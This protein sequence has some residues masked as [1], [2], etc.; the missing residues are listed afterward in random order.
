MSSRPAF[1]HPVWASPTPNPRGALDLSTFREA[2]AADRGRGGA[3]R[4]VASATTPVDAGSPA[5]VYVAAGERLTQAFAA[6][7]P[8]V[9]LELDPNAPPPRI[10]LQVAWTTRRPTDRPSPRACLLLLAHVR[11]VD[12]AERVAR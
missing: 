8:P 7:L 3:G 10:G 2:A 6:G 11:L 9:G 4:T 1:E 5:D 12:G